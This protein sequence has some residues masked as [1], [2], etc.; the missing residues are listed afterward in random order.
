MV[1]GRCFIATFAFNDSDA[2]E[3]VYLREFR[4]QVLLPFR[5]GTYFV[6]KYYKWSPS[7]VRLLSCIPWGRCVSKL[8]ITGMV[9]IIRMIRSKA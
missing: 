4:D 5:A 6:G 7:L 2:P 8:C 9:K 1:D 3:V